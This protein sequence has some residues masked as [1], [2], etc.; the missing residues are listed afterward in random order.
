MS[1]EQP[2]IGVANT[3]K[4]A[5]DVVERLA[6]PFKASPFGAELHALITKYATNA[7]TKE[8][9]QS[10]VEETITQAVVGGMTLGYHPWEVAEFAK[11]VG[12]SL[13][14]KM[15]L[16]CEACSGKGTVDSVMMPGKVSYSCATCKGNGAVPLICERPQD[17]DET[18]KPTV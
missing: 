12:H 13:K 9:M 7:D 14:D 5:D 4:A 17:A 1:E 16:V 8:A 18:W 6:E 10:L 3:I 2:E 11:N 15:A